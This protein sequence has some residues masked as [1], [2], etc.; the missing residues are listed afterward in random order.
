M[1]IQETDKCWRIPLQSF[2]ER[3]WYELGI[4]HVPNRNFSRRPP[5]CVA[6]GTSY[7]SIMGQVF[8]ETVS[9][10]PTKNASAITNESSDSIRTGQQ[11]T[12]NSSGAKFI[13]TLETDPLVEAEEYS[14]TA[15]VS[16]RGD[17]RFRL[18]AAAGCRH[19]H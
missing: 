12:I 15:W 17:V 9:I 3:P 10:T 16:P 18:C 2:E 14:L 7:W 13:T 6:N 5:V 4:P 11:S 8:R 1:E 19:S